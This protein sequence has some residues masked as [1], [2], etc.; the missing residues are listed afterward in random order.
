MNIPSVSIAECATSGSVAS[1]FGHVWG[2]AQ[3]FKGAIITYDN[4]LKTKYLGVDERKIADFV[5]CAKDI[6]LEMA[7][8]RGVTKMFD[9]RYGISTSGYATPYPPEKITIPYVWYCIYDSKKDNV[10]EIDRISNDG[11][12]SREEFQKKVG[13]ML[14]VKYMIAVGNVDV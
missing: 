11:F 4:K 1:Q 5:G 2:A 12:L 6:V 13:M 7:M 14:H 10:V 9:T 8:A 3:Y